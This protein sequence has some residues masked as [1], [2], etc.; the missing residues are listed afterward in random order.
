M[1]L[2][3]RL[4]SRS[5]HSVQKRLAPRQILVSPDCP[6]VEWPLIGLHTV[7][8]AAKDTALGKQNSK[9]SRKGS[10]KPV[11][12]CCVGESLEKPVQK[13]EG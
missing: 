11:W 2:A 8:S 13:E 3:H 4:M 1:G 12:L 10:K 7:S 6:S 9:V 5:S